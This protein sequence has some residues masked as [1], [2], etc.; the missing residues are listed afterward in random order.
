MDGLTELLRHLAA[1]LLL[2]SAGELLI[3][4]GR[5]ASVV[6][7]VMGLAIVAV[8]LEALPDR[9]PEDRFFLPDI[10][11]EQAE[12]EEKGDA[13]TRTLSAEAE[14]LYAAE[15]A[16]AAEQAALTVDGITAAE[17][18]VRITESGEVEE[19]KL[20]LYGDTALMSAA[21]AAAGDAL[22][23]SEDAVSWECGGELHGE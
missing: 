4:G 5:L 11:A 10:R 12:I 2:A 15:L 7:L 21:A 6:R 20:I 8:M 22:G 14:M 17:A 23:L 19:L 3:P 16:A 13:L 9:F 1:L 18:A